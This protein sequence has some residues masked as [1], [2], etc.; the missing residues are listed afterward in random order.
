MSA[1]TLATSRHD[2]AVAMFDQAP[3]FVLQSLRKRC[4]EAML[5]VGQPNAC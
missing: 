2:D 1:S 5:W 3:V 4:G